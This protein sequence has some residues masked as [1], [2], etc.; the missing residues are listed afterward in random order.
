MR[1]LE[2]DRNLITI[3]PLDTVQFPLAITKQHIC[4]GCKKQVDKVYQQGLCKS[5]LTIAF[6]RL[7]KVIDS[8]RK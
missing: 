7:V 3:Y 6:K 1:L 8:V 5:C 2:E 4:K